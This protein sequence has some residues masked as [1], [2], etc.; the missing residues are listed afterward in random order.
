M[1]LLRE[2]GG[3]RL[4]PLINECPLALGDCR[5]PKTVFGT[6]HDLPERT[7]FL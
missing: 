1:L 2:G 6:H 5:L 3:L 4:P 7:Y